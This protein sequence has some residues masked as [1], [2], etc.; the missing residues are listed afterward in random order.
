MSI[1]MLLKNNK[2]TVSSALGKELANEVLG[3]KIEILMEAIE[4]VNYKLDNSKAKSIRA[5]AA[6]I[7]EKV[8]E[9][10]LDKV[11]PHLEKL[12]PAL[13]VPEPQTR[14][15]LIRVLGF[16][17][18][19]NPNIAL[20]GVEDAKLVFPILENALKKAVNL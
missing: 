18:Q 14:W 19:L 15:M 16:C 3:G 5:G 7:I 4:L 1:Y 9:K 8:A 11:A 6:K 10:E 12:V 17:A 2:G 13:S 20:T